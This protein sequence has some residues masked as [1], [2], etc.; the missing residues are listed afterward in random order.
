MHNYLEYYTKNNTVLVFLHIEKKTCLCFLQVL[1]TNTKGRYKV[2]EFFERYMEDGGGVLK[3]DRIGHFNL[4]SS[5]VLV[6]EAPDNFEFQV[7]PGQ[8]VKY[9]QPLGHL[10][11]NMD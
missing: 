3:G 10:Q 6:F 5:I 1:Q 2:G 7:R 4:G 9:G 11:T 8:T